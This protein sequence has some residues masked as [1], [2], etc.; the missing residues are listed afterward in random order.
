[1]QGP[2][3]A[4]CIM[5]CSMTPTMTSRLAL[6]VIFSRAGLD[7]GAK[8]TELHADRVLPARWTSPQTGDAGWRPL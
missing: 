5:I 2:L 4:G 6:L 1:M 3:E 8:C 7:G